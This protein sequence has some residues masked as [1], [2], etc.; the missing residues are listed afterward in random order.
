MK[1]RVTLIVTLAI[2][3][4]LLT[5]GILVGSKLWMKQEAQ[6]GET[7]T[8][9]LQPSETVTPTDQTESREITLICRYSFQCGHTAEV[10]KTITVQPGEEDKILEGYPGFLVE[11]I[12]DDRIILSTQRDCYCPDHYVLV[13]QDQRVVVLKTDSE[14][15][16]PVVLMQLDEGYLHENLKAYSDGMAFDSLEDI[17]LYL[18]GVDE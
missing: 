1:R 18:E 4:G 3:A 12:S 9:A 10:S 14:T 7:I 11:E 8:V 15:M 16:E 17:N 13:A 2:L 6:T 5:L